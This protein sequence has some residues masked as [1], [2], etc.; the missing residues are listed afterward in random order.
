MENIVLVGS[1]GCMREILWQIYERMP[2][3]GKYLDMWI[4]KKRKEMKIVM[5]VAY[6]VRI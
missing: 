2:K 3:N 4:I 1:G 6:V 5:S